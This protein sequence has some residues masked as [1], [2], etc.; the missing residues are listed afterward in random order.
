MDLSPK[1]GVGVAV[2]G[3]TDKRV[4][5]LDTALTQVNEA[6]GLRR[7]QSRDVQAQ[8]RRGPGQGGDVA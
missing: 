8:R 5:E 2:N 3:G 7:R 1:P 4:A 6:A